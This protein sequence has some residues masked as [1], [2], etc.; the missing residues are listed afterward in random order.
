MKYQKGATYFELDTWLGD[1]N[2]VK[3]QTKNDY[4]LTINKRCKNLAYL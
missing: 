1:K 4:Y 3:A 2:K